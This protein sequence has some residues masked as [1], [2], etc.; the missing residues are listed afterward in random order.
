MASGSRTDKPTRSK[1]GP[2]LR[3]QAHEQVMQL[4]RLAEKSE[5]P[6]LRA[7]ALELAKEN[8]K[9]FR[10]Q[11][12][13]VSPTLIL[14]VTILLG[15]AVAGVCWYAFLHYSAPKAYQ[16]CT[17]VILIY[18]VIVGVC[19]FLSGHLSQANFMKILGWLASHI[20]SGWNSA[21]NKISGDTDPQA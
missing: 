16:V 20:K 8:S 9:Y 5:H 12:A 3:E 7:A 4:F 19:L 6:E 15:I 18:L 10:K 14:S 21:L 1:Q 2:Q 17:I 11:N 13:R